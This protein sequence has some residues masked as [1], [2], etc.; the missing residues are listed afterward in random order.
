M[1]RLAEAD[2]GAAEELYG[3]AFTGQERMLLLTD[4]KLLD[5]IEQQRAYLLAMALVAIPCPA[6]AMM[7]CQRA[8][9]LTDWLHA[10]DNGY[11]CQACHMPLIWVLP[12]TGHQFFT[13]NLE[14][15]HLQHQ[16]ASERAVAAAE[17]RAEDSR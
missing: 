10:P 2:L 4:S 5:P 3:I 6:C 15:K 1:R 11:A 9:A 16:I 7:T 8:A 13:V 14:M 17:Q 12:F